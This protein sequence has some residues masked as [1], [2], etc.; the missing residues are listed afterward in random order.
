MDKILSLANTSYY[1]ISDK[2]HKKYESDL[3]AIDGIVSVGFTK[4]L[5][6]VD[7]FFKRDIEVEFTNSNAQKELETLLKEAFVVIED[8]S[9]YLKDYIKVTYTA[10]II[11][12][13][14]VIEKIKYKEQVCYAF[15]E[16]NEQDNLGIYGSFSVKEENGKYFAESNLHV[17]ASERDF[18]DFAKGKISKLRDIKV[19]FKIDNQYFNGIILE[20]SYNFG[21]NNNLKD[22]CKCCIN[23]EI[24]DA[25]NDYIKPKKMIDSLNADDWMKMSGATSKR[26]LLERLDDESVWTEMGYSNFT[27]ELYLFRTRRRNITKEIQ[28]GDSGSKIYYKQKDNEN[29]KEAILVGA[30]N[31]YAYVFKVNN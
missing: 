3:K 24:Y 16:K 31:K 30:S 23:Q 27:K 2:L 4:S 10:K 1:E 19:S 28:N 9:F 17:L 11:A 14:D 22:Y 5:D 26:V 18:N 12:L 8:N 29:I 25:Y 15:N 20:D 6:T 7:G 13:T 21:N